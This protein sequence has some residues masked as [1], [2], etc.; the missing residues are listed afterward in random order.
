MT[1]RRVVK[2]RLKRRSLNNTCPPE[3]S[4]SE[5]DTPSAPFDLNH[6]KQLFELMEKHD[7]REVRLR[8]GA[9]KWELRRGPQEVHVAPPQFA[10]F[11]PPHAPPASP[12][13]AHAPAAAAPVAAPA[14]DA[15]LTPIK[16]PTVG[17]FYQSPQPS[18]PPF[19]KVGDK[20][21]AETV[22]CVI[23]AM[24]VF[25]QIPSTVG[26]TIVKILV[27]DGDAVEFNQPLFLVRV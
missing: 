18:D 14:D 25:N 7:V 5:H 19:V 2:Y 17:T 13:A 11:A 10:H 1:G 15:N 23:E 20:V 6:L 4:M 26:G 3:R 16:S 27:K 21:K 22:V 24:K 8:H 12:V 9:E